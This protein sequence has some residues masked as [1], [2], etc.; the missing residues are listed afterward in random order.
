MI[1]MD[2]TEPNQEEL[3]R[4]L[5]RALRRVM[6]AYARRWKR[7]RHERKDAGLAQWSLTQAVRVRELAKAWEKKI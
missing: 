2:K 7:I 4:R 1:F 3:R 5:V 6:S